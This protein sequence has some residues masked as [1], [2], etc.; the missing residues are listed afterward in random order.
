MLS[1]IQLFKSNRLV[2]EPSAED[3]T[4]MQLRKAYRKLA[5]GPTFTL[6]RLGS[7]PISI[8]FAWFFAPFLGLFGPVDV[9]RGPETPP[10]QAPRP[11]FGV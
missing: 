3:A 1:D 9:L 7:R 11:R 2:L 5:R 6:I 4:E 10:R 8:D